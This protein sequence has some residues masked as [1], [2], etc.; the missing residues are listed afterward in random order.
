MQLNLWSNARRLSNAGLFSFRKRG[1]ALRL[2]LL[3]LVVCN[4]L[5]I[6][7]GS[8]GRRSGSSRGLHPVALDLE[9]LIA[10]LFLGAHV[11]FSRG[12]A[13][14]LDLHPFV[15]LKSLKPALGSAVIEINRH[16]LDFVRREIAA[17]GKSC[18]CSAI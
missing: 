17:V 4:G 14:L 8:F 6:P 15:L 3:D 11:R 1:A 10:L 7:L 9:L 16:T 12:C 2:F 13:L 18:K 5:G